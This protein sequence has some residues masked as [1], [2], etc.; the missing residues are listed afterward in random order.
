[1]SESIFTDSFPSVKTNKNL[2]KI[3][4]HYPNYDPYYVAS[5]CIKERQEKFDKLWKSYKPL[6]DKHFL[7]DIK[8][9]FHQR[10]WE[11]Y[12]GAVLVKNNFGISSLDRGPD[13]VINKGRADEFFI[14][15]VACEKGDTKDKVPDIIYNTVAQN[16]FV[17]QDVPENEMLIRLVNSLESK[18]KKYKDFI[19][20][21]N[22]PY[23]IAVNKGELDHLDPQIPLILKCLFGIEFQSLPIR[24]GSPGRPHWTRRESICKKSGAKV[25][26]TF[27]EQKEHNE[28]SGVIYS[29]ERVLNHPNN[30]GED[31][32]LVH[33]PNAKN[34]ISF[35]RFNFFEQW[36]KEDDYIKKYAHK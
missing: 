24:G 18:Y 27:F 15:A 16:V 11:M 17:A 3:K 36:Y 22:K 26:M 13:F 1:M 28:I 14:E 20:K 6:A 34:R 4:E 29:T 23:I 5:G 25:L 35:S 7:S 2:Q 8:K 21:E 12:L 19:K 9:H 31:C 10:T 33:N 30:L 32:I